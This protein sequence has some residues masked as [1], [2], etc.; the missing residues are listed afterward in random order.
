MTTI[1][2]L[3]IAHQVILE[4]TKRQREQEER[5][6]REQVQCSLQIAQRVTSAA[7]EK[8]YISRERIYFS[9]FRN[10]KDLITYLNTNKIDP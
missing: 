6:K 9:D 1:D 10:Y 3:E 2:D 4:R 8:A 7:L 5:M